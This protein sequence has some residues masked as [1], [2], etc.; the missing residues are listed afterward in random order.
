MTGARSVGQMSSRGS[1]LEPRLALYGN[2]SLTEGGEIFAVRNVIAQVVAHGTR[3]VQYIGPGR[4]VEP[5]RDYQLPTR[6]SS[7]PNIPFGSPVPAHIAG[8]GHA[9][10]F[11]E[12]QFDF[13]LREGL[14]LDPLGHDKHLS[15]VDVYRT[16]AETIRKSPSITMNVSSVS[17]WSCH[18]K[19]P[20]NFTTLN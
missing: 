16:V 10:R 15:R 3:P 18:R 19:S 5:S 20:F 6:T 4:L 13:P 1:R 17:L 8:V 9:A 7:N 11:D 12:Q 2:E 14:V